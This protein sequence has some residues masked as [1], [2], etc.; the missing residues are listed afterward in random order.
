[1]HVC[2]PDNREE[3][4]EDHKLR[5]SKSREIRNN[6]LR[7]RLFEVLNEQDRIEDFFRKD[8]SRDDWK[9]DNWNKVEEYVQAV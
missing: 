4:I 2:K 5:I 8:D 7:N 9:Y 3:D 1:M 6:A